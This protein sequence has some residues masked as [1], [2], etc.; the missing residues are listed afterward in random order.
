[1]TGG[2]GF[3]RRSVHARDRHVA[4]TAPI[5]ITVLLSG[6]ESRSQVD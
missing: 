6:S 1:V 5:A 3:V 4:L 2:G